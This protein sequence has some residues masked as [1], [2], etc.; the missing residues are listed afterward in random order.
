MLRNRL[1]VC[2]SVVLAGCDGVDAEPGATR[3]DTVEANDT[4]APSETTTTTGTSATDATSE[5]HEDASSSAPA[6]VVHALDIGQ[7]DGFII[8]FPCGAM[9]VD[10]GGELT[11]ATT[12]IPAFDSDVALEAQVRAFFDARPHLDKTLDLVVL[13]HPHIDH[14]RGVSK[15]IAM[16]AAGDLVIKNVVTNGDTN[17]GSG[18]QQQRALHDFAD[19]TPGVGRWYVLQRRTGA[20]GET[21]EVIDPFSACERSDVDPVITAL[22]GRID[23]ESPLATTWFEDDFYNDNNH[24]VVLRIDFGASSMLLNGDLEEAGIEGLMTQYADTSLL[25]V[26]LYKV[27]HH[28]SYNATTPALINVMTPRAAIMSCGPHDRVGEFTAWAFGHPRWT[29]VRDLIGDIDSVGV[30]SL[31]R[32]AIDA[33][34]SI[35]YFNGHGVFAPRRVAPAVYSTSWDGA[36]TF[37]LHADGVLDLP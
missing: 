20:T 37:G 27:G 22:W 6:M 2:L 15:L 35:D 29:V 16:V 23:E 14:T 28:G 7:G 21:N 19:E 18:I 31:R 17:G 10:T 32:E 34:V 36:V 5:V 26:D 11:D 8:E 3:A 33:I 13:S 9:M 30:S 1:I 25:D 24:S 4:T 12:G